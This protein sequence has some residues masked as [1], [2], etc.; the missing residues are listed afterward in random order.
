M[1]FPYVRGKQFELIALRE[2]CGLLPN[3]STKISPVIEP[4]KG[5][6]TLKSALKTLASKNVNFSVIINPKVGGLVGEGNKIIDLLKEVLQHYNNYQIAIIIDTKIEEQIPALIEGVNSLELDYKGV[7]LIHNSEI[8]EVSITEIQSNINVIYNI[9]YFSHTSRRYYRL[10]SEDSRISLDDYFRDMPRNADYL[11]VGESPFSEEYS[12][13]KDEGFFGFSDFLTVGD[14]YSD[15]GFLPRAVAMHLSYINASGKIMVK[16]F[17]SDSN[18][19]VSD[20]GGKFAEALE[21]LVN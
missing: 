12:F 5:S 18:G 2:L 8:S 7:T 21:K 16:H 20:I 19:D 11:E 10:F 1:Y 9:I 15:S 13:Y 4:I 14:N 6:S 3:F 17:V